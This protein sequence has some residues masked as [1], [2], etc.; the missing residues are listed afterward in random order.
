MKL[1]KWLKIKPKRHFQTQNDLKSHVFT[2]NR[3]LLTQKSLEMNFIPPESPTFQ[4]TTF[5]TKHARLHLK[6]R[7][8]HINRSKHGRSGRTKLP[9]VHDVHAQAMAPIPSFKTSSQ[10]LLLEVFEAS[11]YASRGRFRSVSTRRR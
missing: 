8:R 5:Y 7:R 3:R 10:T 2:Q 9:N 6:Q 4:K 11:G 1:L